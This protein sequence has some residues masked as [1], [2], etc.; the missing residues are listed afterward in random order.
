MQCGAPVGDLSVGA[1]DIAK[2][3]DTSHNPKGL[4]YAKTPVPGKQRNMPRATSAKA[5][6]AGAPAPVDLAAIKV[7]A[8]S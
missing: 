6:P 8:G 1:L 5:R 7:P 3:L 2:F 4:P